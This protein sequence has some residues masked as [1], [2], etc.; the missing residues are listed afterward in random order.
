M[1]PQDSS[2]QKKYCL[3]FQF[4]DQYQEEALFQ[5]NMELFAYEATT[6]LRKGIWTHIV[7]TFE[8]EKEDGHIV[9]TFQKFKEKTMYDLPWRQI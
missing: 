3:G 1:L 9:H 7:H 8:K 5:L 4:G 6:I 2:V